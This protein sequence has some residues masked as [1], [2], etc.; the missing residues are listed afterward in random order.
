MNFEFHNQIYDLVSSL[1]PLMSINPTF[2]DSNKVHKDQF[3]KSKF[4]FA[5]LKVDA[6]K[7]NSNCKKLHL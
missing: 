1:R 7:T 4:K 5:H 3:H 6:C 2:F